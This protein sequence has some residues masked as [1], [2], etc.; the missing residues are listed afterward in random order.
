MGEA[1]PEARAG[2]LVGGARDWG[3]VP[4]H[5]WLE[6]GPGVSGCR[7]LEVPG[8]VLMHWC[9]GPGSGPSNGQGC[10]QGRL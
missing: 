6:L 5:W 8:L 2:S 10:V 7:A 4:A 1:C 9:V 3:L